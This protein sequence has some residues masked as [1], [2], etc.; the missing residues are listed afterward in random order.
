MAIF[1]RQSYNISP[2]IWGSP[3][4][5]QYAIWQN[6]EEIYGCNHEDEVLIMPGFWGL[7]CLDYS[8]FGNDGVNSGV[9]FKDGS[10]NFDAA[11]A[12][13]G[14]NNTGMTDTNYF[15]SFWI[16][17]K[18]VTTTQYVFDQTTAITGRRSVVIGYQD[19]YFNYYDGAY[20]T[21]TAADTQIVATQDVW[22]YIVMGT[23]GTKVYGYKNGQKVV[24]ETG[25][26]VSTGATH[27]YIGKGYRDFH[28][29][30][31]K[32]FRAAKA[33][34]TPAQIALFHDN[35]YGLYRPVSRPIWSIP[36]VG[37]IAPTSTIY[38]PF[39]GPMGG[40]V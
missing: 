5:R 2:P 19:G 32:E 6:L 23:D 10:M 3:A 4:D 20:P 7:P 21:G 30:S 38:G 16:N 40:P 29:R 31:I 39:L 8:K 37:A 9:I 11:D 14:C 24:E 18:D 25:T 12:F 26:W 1:L 35:P 27:F 17:P 36:A 22:Q 28:G 33:A 15:L 34:R 13:F